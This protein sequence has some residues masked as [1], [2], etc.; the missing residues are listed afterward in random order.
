MPDLQ[1]EQER[2]TVPT[3]HINGLHKISSTDLEGYVYRQY[4]K[5][6]SI[7]IPSLQANMFCTISNSETLY[8][9]C[10]KTP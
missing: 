3:L 9:K 7:L 10:V 1:Q 4:E 2:N 5:D 6:V 8:I